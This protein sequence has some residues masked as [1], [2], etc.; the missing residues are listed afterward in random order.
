MSEHIPTIYHNPRCTKSR[1]TLQL[2]RDRGVEPRIVDYQQ[3]P[4]SNSELA[5]ILRMLDAPAEHLIRDKERRGLGLPAAAD[6]SAI[7]EQ[8][9]QHPMI[10]QRPIVVANGKARIGRPPENVLEIL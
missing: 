4:P 2:L 10:M 7:I 1:Q 9:S 3:T 6:Q 5:D 8:L